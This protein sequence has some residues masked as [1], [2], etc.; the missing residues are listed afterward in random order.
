MRLTAPRYGPAM[1]DAT[2]EERY[3][4]F[5]AAVFGRLCRELRAMV[6]ADAEDLAQEALLVARRRWDLVQALDLPHAWVRRVALRMAARR[7][8]RERDRPAVEA[9][10]E[11]PREDDIPDLDVVAAL[12]ELPDRHAAAV[13]LHHLEDRPVAAV[14]ERLGCSEGAAKV[15]LLRARRVLA[16][17]VMG[18]T[19]TWVAER[20]W[21]A[22]EIARYLRATGF[23]HR[24][25]PI[26]DGDFEGRGGRW[27]LTVADGTYELRREDG[28]RLDHGV[29]RVGRSTFE[30]APILNTG[31]ARYAMR[32]D[33]RRLALRFADAT[34]PPH[35]EMP[36]GGWAG[37]FFDA[38]PFVRKEAPS[39]SM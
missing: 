35:L 30:M 28:A 13:R 3:A 5:Y 19:G 8:R 33:G 14:A 17:R 39:R 31:R 12:L 18:L 2:D 21:S 10:A 36:E 9:L 26:L 15:L 24:T 27:E 22:D 16:E 4:A 20:T 32:V 23:G 25:E 37:I 7:V 29:S 38:A 11:R 34:I 1:A 6:G